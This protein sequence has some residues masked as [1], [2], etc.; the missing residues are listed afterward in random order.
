MALEFP[1]FNIVATKQKTS[2][3]Q[4]LNPTEQELKVPAVLSISH[5]QNTCLHL[6]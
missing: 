1:R 4:L 2:Q 3:N 5:K 6:C